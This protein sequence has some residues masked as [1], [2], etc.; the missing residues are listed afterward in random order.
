MNAPQI[1]VD[2]SV[3]IS[4][5]LSQQGASYRLLTLIGRGLFD[6]NLS[7]SLFAEYE[8][9][10]KRMLDQLPLSEQDLEEILDYL[11]AVANRRSVFFLWRPFL[12]DPGDDMV[13]ELAVAARVQYIVTYNRRDFRGSEQFGIQIVTPKEFL[14]QIGLLQ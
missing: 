4:A 9:V 1:V 7:I 12:P 6:V 10:A 14:D 13:L 2:T 11:C 5:L 3:F 8:A